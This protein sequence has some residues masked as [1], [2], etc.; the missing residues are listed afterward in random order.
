M[1]RTDFNW[2]PT[3]EEL[4]QSRA[5][6][7]QRLEKYLQQ[8]PADEDPQW[9]NDTERRALERPPVKFD[10]L[11][12]DQGRAPEGVETRRSESMFRGD[13]TALE[14]PEPLMAND[15]PPAPAL[16]EHVPVESAA[17]PDTETPTAAAEAEDLVHADIEDSKIDGAAAQSAIEPGEAGESGWATEIARLQALMDGLTEKLEWRVTN[18]AEQ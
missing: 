11:P 10:W 17:S 5:E 12:T 2:P 6:T 8:R 7:V 16:A 18:A 1:R 3:D 15:P 9:A 4:E 14:P 13:G